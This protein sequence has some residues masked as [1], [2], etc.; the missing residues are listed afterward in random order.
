VMGIAFMLLA[1]LLIISF[2]Q[3]PILVLPKE[4]T[5]IVSVASSIGIITLAFLIWQRQTK[6]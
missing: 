4:V 6:I 1:I 2:S 5:C 3:N